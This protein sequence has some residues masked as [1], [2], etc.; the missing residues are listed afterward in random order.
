[1]RVCV[2]VCVC[3]CVLVT[4]SG[5]H[6][7]DNRTGSPQNACDRALVNRASKPRR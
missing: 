1:M 6:R 3:V 4:V 7:P 5:F 2:C